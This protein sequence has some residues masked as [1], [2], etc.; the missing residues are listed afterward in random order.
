MTSSVQAI[1]NNSPGNNH[2]TSKIDE[3]CEY[4]SY[5]NRQL[6]MECL[7][8]HT[9]KPSMDPD[10]DKGDDNSKK[11]TGETDDDNKGNVGD[12][13]NIKDKENKKITTDVNIGKSKSKS[14]AR[15]RP[16]TPRAPTPRLSWLASTT[17]Q[18]SRMKEP[19]SGPASLAALAVWASAKCSG[20]LTI[21][22]SSAG[23]ATTSRM[24]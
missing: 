22:T 17:T 8:R 20:F 3:P 12:E 23:R 4:A 15:S 14:R 5:E 2:D 9:V 21:S 19:G 10:V 16:R 13:N 18:L 7:R 6:V 1:I 11:N 24:R